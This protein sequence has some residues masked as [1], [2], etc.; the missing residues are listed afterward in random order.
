ML[1]TGVSALAKEAY[2]QMAAVGKYLISDGKAEIAM[3]RSA[4]PQSISHNATVLVLGVRG[5]QTAIKGT[6]GFVVIES[7]ARG[8]RSRAT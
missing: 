8:R 3:A 4:A 6:N 5:Y 1:T 7:G 2:P